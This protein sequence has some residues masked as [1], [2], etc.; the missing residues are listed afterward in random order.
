MKELDENNMMWVNS[1]IQRI[2]MI[3]A[4]TSLNL[5]EFGDYIYSLIE[6][7]QP[8]F[9]DIPDIATRYNLLKLEYAKL[10]SQY[11]LLKSETVSNS[12]ITSQ[13]QAQID[14]LTPEKEKLNAEFETKIAEVETQ[15]NKE[16]ET[17]KS[18]IENIT[19][20]LN[21]KAQTEYV[22]PNIEES[23]E[24][25]TDISNLTKTEIKEKLVELGVDESAVK[26]LT[27]VEAI[28]L[29][30]ETEAQATEVVVEE[31]V[32]E[33]SEETNTEKTE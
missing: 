18:E 26:P 29:L 1:E 8:T 12:M 14:T 15:K 9:S 6:K 2:E 33:E 13:L 4:Y 19:L 10:E 24:V 23:A 17:L 25:S 3:E 21:G 5:E 31:S 22:E 32:V 28:E 30:I 16:I 7:Q 11:Q 20:A 27:K